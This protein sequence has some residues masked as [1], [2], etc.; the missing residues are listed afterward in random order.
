[1]SFIKKLYKNVFTEQR[2]LFQ[3]LKLDSKFE[4]APIVGVFVQTKK[5]TKIKSYLNSDIDCIKWTFT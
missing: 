3:G 2:E 5:F 1:M 4:E